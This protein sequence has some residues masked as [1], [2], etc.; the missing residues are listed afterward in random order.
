MNKLNMWC[1][2]DIREGYLNVDIVNLPWVDKVFN[3]ESFPYPF[4]DN[5]FDEIYCS[6]IL[7]HM[8]D[9]WKVMD[10][11]Y[12]IWKN[13]CKIKIKVPYFASPNAMWDYTHKRMF[14]THSFEYFTKDC[15]YNN[16]DFKIVK[17]RIHRLSNHEFLKSE[18]IGNKIMDPIVNLF[19]VFFERFFCY[20][21]PCVEIHYL[22]EVKK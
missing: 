21:I 17:Q 9:L 18:W 4:E 12:R 13:W 22:L 2:K 16:V 3:F 14:N 20:I 11:F 6:H 10:E 7:E 5:T 19:P 1:W 15:Y 8:S